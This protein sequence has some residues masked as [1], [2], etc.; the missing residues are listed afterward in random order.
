MLKSFADRETERLW[1]RRRSSATPASLQ[2]RALRKLVIL[3]AAGS[4]EDLHIPPG[5][6]LEKLGGKRKGQHSIRINEQFRICFVW[7]GED[8]HEV[9][10]TD[11]H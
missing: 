1:E 8:A 10:I 5:N 3:D 7:H 4:L 6:R 11:Y 9:E 2:R